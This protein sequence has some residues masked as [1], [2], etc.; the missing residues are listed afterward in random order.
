MT[1]LEKVKENLLLEHDRDDALLGSYLAAAISYAERYCEI[2]GRHTNNSTIAI[3][4]L[5]AR[6]KFDFSSKYKTR[7]CVF[8]RGKRIRRANGY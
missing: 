6:K 4:G 7:R 2:N 8:E 1:L 5:K 3:H